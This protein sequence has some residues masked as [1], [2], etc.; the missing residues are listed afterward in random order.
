MIAFLI[1]VFVGAVVMLFL[2]GVCMAGRLDYQW[3]IR[4]LE[5]QLAERDGALEASVRALGGRFL[6]L[7]CLPSGQ[8]LV[9]GTP[10]VVVEPD[11]RLALTLTDCAETWQEVVAG[12]M[13]LPEVDA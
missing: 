7:T 3:R 10:R 2:V 4:F 5:R 13:A 12:A 8:W 9:G 1:G 11:A 6:W